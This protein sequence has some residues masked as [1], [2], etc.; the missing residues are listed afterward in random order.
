MLKTRIIPCLLLKQKGLVK[1]VKFDK[2]RYVGDPINAI[3]IYNEKEA[4]ELVFLDI[5]ATKEKRVPTSELVTQISDEC[6]MPLAVGGGIR[7]ME[8]V[9]RLLKAGAEKVVLNTIAV[10]DPNF[11]KKAADAFGNQSIT[12]SIDAKKSFFGKYE[13][14][15]NSGTRNTK[16]NPVEF[17]KEM[18]QK[19]AGEIFINSINLDG[20]REGYD[21]KLIKMVSDS[22]TIPVIA[23]GGAGNIED[24]GKAVHEGGASAV[25]AG[26]MFVFHGRRQAVL[27]NFPNKDEIRRV[28]PTK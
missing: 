19:G 23:C 27:I 24:F 7:T 3:K 8:D 5:T 20:T 10:E 17:A 14:F 16:L 25:A 11:V 15:T 21:L 13:V 2:P 18:E 6:L 22:V 9:Q 26:S 1:T 4:H 28:F 12:V